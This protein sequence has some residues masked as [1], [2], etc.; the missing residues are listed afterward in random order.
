MLIKSI[1][2]HHDRRYK[3]YM[4]LAIGMLSMVKYCCTREINKNEE[5]YKK[6]TGNQ[7]IKSL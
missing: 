5:A 3:T 6:Y 4:T 1:N 7:I 2:N